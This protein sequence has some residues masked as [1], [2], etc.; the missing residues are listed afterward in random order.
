MFGDL[1]IKNPMKP[2]I[3]ATITI[4]ASI[5]KLKDVRSFIEQNGKHAK[6]ADDVLFDLTFVIDEVCT[7]IFTHGYKDMTPGDV[8]LNFSVYKDRAVI[9]IV[10]HGRAFKPDEI[11]K[12]DIKADWQERKIGGL[13]WHLIKKLTDEADYQ[14]D[15]AKGNRLILVKMLDQRSM[16]KGEG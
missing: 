10:D 2:D 3:E 8:V 4:T 15:P 13:G 14:S 5:E 1:R 9:T 12:P 7:N 11:E 16:E 6:I